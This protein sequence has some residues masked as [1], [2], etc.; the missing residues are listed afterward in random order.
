MGV[1]NSWRSTI[2]MDDW[3]RD[4]EKRLMHEE[5]RPVVAPAWDVVGPGI[6]T[7]GV[8]V[9]DWDSNGPIVNG[10]FYSMTG[11]VVNSPDDGLNWMGMV[12]ADPDGAGIQRVWEYL[13]TDNTPA[14]NAQVFQ[15]TFITN[16]D[17]TRTYS[18]WAEEGGGGGGGSVTEQLLAQARV[19]TNSN[20]DLATG[21]L[22]TIDG[23]VLAEGDRVVVKDQATQS[24][25]GVYI[26]SVA[27]WV[28]APD[29]DTAANVA[30]GTRIRVT[31]GNNNQFKTYT[32]YKT[33]TTIDSD[34]QLWD[35]ITQVDSGNAFTYPEPRGIGHLFFDDNNKALSVWNGAIWVRTGLTLIVTSTTRPGFVA[36]GTTIYETDTGASLVWQ[37]GAWRTIGGSGSG[38]AAATP[39]RARL[40]K[41]GTQPLADGTT[42]QVTFA[43][44]EYT[45]PAG[46]ADS[47]NNRLAIPADGDYVVTAY[48]ILSGSVSGGTRT[49]IIRLNGTQIRAQR[50]SPNNSNQVQ[51]ECTIARHFVAGD[52]LT[53]HAL[54]NGGASTIEGGDMFSTA[55]E[56]VRTDGIKGDKGDPGTG[57]GGITDGDKGDITVSGGGTTWTIDNGAVTSAKIADGTIATG[58]LAFTPIKSGDAAGGGLSGTYPNPSI[59]SP[60]T[61]A[62]VRTDALSCTTPGSGVTSTRL[63]MPSTGSPAVSPTVGSTWEQTVGLVRRPMSTTASTSIAAYTTFLPTGT[64]LA[65][66]CGFQFVS[67]ATLPAKT[68]SGTFSIVIPMCQQGTTMDT[69]LQVVIRVVS[70][71]GTVERGVLYSGQTATGASATTTDPNY[72]VFVASVNIPN[73]K[74]RILTNVPMTPVAT[75]AGDR[76][77]VEVGGRCIFPNG[78]SRTYSMVQGDPSVADFSLTVDQAG[79]V[80]RPWVSFDSDVFGSGGCTL[81]VNSPIDMNNNTLCGLPTPAADNCAATKAYV[82]SKTPVAGAGLTQ[83]GTTLNVGAGTG[84][85]VNADDVAVVFAGNGAAN[86]AA[87]SDHNHAST[88]AAITTAI[89]TTAPLTGGGDL[90]ASRTLGVTD[91]TSGA[92]G[93]VPASGGGTTNFLRADGTWAA[94]PGGGGSGVTTGVKG[95]INVVGA[96]TDWQIVANAVGSNE[97]AAGAVDNSEI[98]SNAVDGT[99]IAPLS[100]GTTHIDNGA[101]TSTKIADGTIA[102]GDMSATGT[103]DSTTFLRGDN[104]WAVPPGGGGSDTV[105]V[106]TRQVFTASGTWTKPANFVYAEV[107]CVGGGGGASGVAN[108][109][110][111]E[112]NTGCAG[113][114]GGYSRKIWLDAALSATETVTVG[115][116][117]TAGAA[118]NTGP[119]GNGGASIFKTQ[120][121]NGGTGGPAAGVGGTLKQSAGGAGGGASGGDFNITGDDGDTSR[122][123]PNTGGGATPSVGGGG[124]SFYGGRTRSGA[125]DTFS[126]GGVAGAQYGG[127]AS[128]GYSRN[129]GGAQ[130]GAAGFAGVVIVTSYVRT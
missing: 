57:G 105:L 50:V 59:A 104:T 9:E 12:L 46:F 40:Y 90:S 112:A 5:R 16:D 129:A 117:G 20:V 3:M 29:A 119:G 110:A 79:D 14:P 76:L 56:A 36:E 89:N 32:Q 19:A 18:D 116:A 11:Q 71:D 33:V 126:G 88:Y 111:N 106:P 15:R 13:T 28:R 77:V 45:E 54:N 67:T 38:G 82:D 53:M 42:T 21:G 123:M 47:A 22:L 2:T 48:L 23:I 70:N 31:E 30:R 86:S 124:G 66:H 65:D 108:T 99:K 128:P 100:V 61:V 44:T 114:G 55:F 26:A 25:N 74:T 80:G 24:E 58:D 34:P 84:I 4:I 103:K 27:S 52:L 63:Y 122:V 10:F 78:S 62:E 73:C 87:R 68:I 96:D 51:I 41:S 1:N 7:Y 69:F 94:P 102:L 35:V 6:S 60:M 95:D 91:F 101:V 130:V 98:A 75:T 39:M 115:A 121:G 109:A 8:L 107:E 64:T 118:N 92:R 113:G 72:E 81:E 83:S 93:T 120:Q 49:V 127:G 97:I 37:G 85:A 17:G 125:V 43:I